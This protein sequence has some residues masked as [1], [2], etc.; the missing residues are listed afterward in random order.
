MS[1]RESITETTKQN[2]GNSK[3]QTETQYGQGKRKGIQGGR[4]DGWMDVSLPLGGLVL[5]NP[6]PR[7]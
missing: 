3:R 7:W 1:I 4:M 2:T 6:Q 5:R